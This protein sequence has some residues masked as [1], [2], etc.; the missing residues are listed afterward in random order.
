[1]YVV[2]YKAKKKIRAGSFSEAM[3]MGSEIYHHLKSVI[4]SHFGLDAIAVG[5]EGGFAPNILNN[6]DGLSLIVTAIEKAG[7]TGKVEIGIDVAASE[8]YREGK[9]HLDFK[10]PNSDNTAWLSGQELVNLYHEFIK[11]FPV[12]SIEDLFD[13]DDWN[14]WNSF[15]ATANIQIVADD[16]TVTN[17]IRI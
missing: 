8:F 11:E 1:M 10:N 2:K 14:G 9:Y 15:A 12:T 7:Y 4:K 6:K 5:D 16:L 17:P 3:R 13:Q